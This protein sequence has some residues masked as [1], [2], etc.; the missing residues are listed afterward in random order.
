MASLTP[1]QINQAV[2][3]LCADANVSSV[4]KGYNVSK[5]GTFLLILHLHHSLDGFLRRTRVTEPLTM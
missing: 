2:G 4:G 1:D 3:K 5:H